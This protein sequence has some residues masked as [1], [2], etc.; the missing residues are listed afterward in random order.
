[1]TPRKDKRGRKPLI[2]SPEEG[3]LIQWL[4]SDPL[5]RKLPWADLR[6]YIPG[7]ELYGEHA[8]TTALRSLGYKRVIRPQRIYLT[9]QHK[10]NRLA[11]AYEQL[12]LRP[13]LED[14]ERVL[15]SDETWATNSHAWKRW[16]TI[17]D[18]EDPET[19]AMIRQKP[20]G[21]MFWGSFAGGTKGPSFFWE[22]EYG[23]ISAAKYQHFIVPLVYVFQEEFGDLVFQQDNAA[24]HSARSTKAL[25]AA[26][27]IEVLRWPPRSPDLSPIEN[28]WAWMKGWIEDHYDIETLNLPQLRQAVQAVWEAIPLDFLRRLAHSMPR[29]LRQCIENG[30]GRV[31]Y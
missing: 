22:K 17:H 21:W 10:A 8:I 14:W 3:A 13:R 4:R 6:Y 7:L 29:R 19:W 31:E 5:Y 30:G 25:L 11:F 15:F 20:H 23:G 16:I 24:A 1:L 12:A 28:V 2:K 26:L 27:G 18:I 9:D